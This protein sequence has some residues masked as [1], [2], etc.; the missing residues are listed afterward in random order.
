VKREDALEA[1][2]L[3]A[4]SLD[5]SRRPGS[6]ERYRHLLRR[7]Q[8]EPSFTETVNALAE[9]L[10]LRVLAADELHGLIVDATEGSPFAP[11]LDSLRRSLRIPSTVEDRLIYGLIIAGISAWCYPTADSFTEPGLRHVRA[12]QVERKLRE[13]CERLARDRGDSDGDDPE[14]R[15]AFAAYAARKPYK[16]GKGGAMTHDCTLWMVGHTLRWLADQQFL[17]RDPKDA[18]LY[19]ATDRFRHHVSAAASRRAYELIA[20]AIAAATAPAAEEAG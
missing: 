4:H 2:E 18:E 3:L 13:L 10:G 8:T 5:T 12:A 1:N 16:K 11:T 14:L 7:Y 19:R 20:G 15:R 6:D 9:P 17:L